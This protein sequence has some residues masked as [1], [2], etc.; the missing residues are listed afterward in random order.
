MATGFLH[1]HTLTVLLFLLLYLAKLVLLFVNQDTLARLTRATR[2][3][4][5]VI[6]TLFLLTGIGL[7]VVAPSRISMLVILKIVMVLAAIPLAVIGFRK[8]N[9]VLASLSV[10]LIIG[11][12]GMAEVHAGRVGESTE[13][14]PASVVTDASASNYDLAAHGQALYQRNCVMCHGENGALKYNGASNLQ[15]SELA[16]AGVQAMVKNGVAGKM[17]AYPGYSEQELQ[18]VATYVLTLRP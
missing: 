1:T 2:I 14:L 15:E 3:P 7:M 5:M 8:L 6:S 12:Y 4:E 16:M 18:A 13:P 17:P 11:A 10:L 9:K